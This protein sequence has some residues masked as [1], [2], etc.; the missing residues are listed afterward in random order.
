MKKILVI[1]DNI[2][3]L[4]LI[5]LN[6]EKAGYTVITEKDGKFAMRAIEQEMPD[7]IITDIYMPEKDGIS[8]LSQIR[9]IFTDLP[10]VVMSGGGQL[11]KTSDDRRF[12]ME[13]CK[14]LGANATIDKPI[15]IPNLLGLIAKLI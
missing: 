7:L 10:I 6:L 9:E 12:T 5:T 3:I 11:D 8:V 14:D 13:I 4:T 15:N 2:T 1:D